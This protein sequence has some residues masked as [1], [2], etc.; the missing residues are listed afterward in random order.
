[1]VGTS[2]SR[3][4]N[5]GKPNPGHPVSLAFLPELFAWGCN[6]NKESKHFIGRR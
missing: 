3:G 6:K 1:M 5:P 4:L 2:E